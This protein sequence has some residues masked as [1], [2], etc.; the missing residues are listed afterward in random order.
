MGNFLTYL[1]EY[2]C[3]RSDTPLPNINIKCACFGSKIRNC[4]DIVDGNE[5]TSTEREENAEKNK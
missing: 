5:E 1:Y 3:I 4:N 2:F